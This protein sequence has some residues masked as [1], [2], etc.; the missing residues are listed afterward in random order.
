MAEI[1]FSPEEW[2]PIIAQTLA[3]PEP[4]ATDFA[5]RVSVPPSAEDAERDSRLM[6][7]ALRQ[8]AA[9][10][11]LDEVP[12]GCV[13]AHPTLGL[14]GHGHNRR[15]TTHDPTAHAE[16]I[17]IR[18]AAERIGTW[19]LDECELFVTLEP[20]PMC[21]GALV[22]ARIARV[23]FGCF[24]AKAG[25][26]GSVLRLHDHPV[27]NHRFPVASSVLRDACAEMLSEFFR[28]K[29]ALGKK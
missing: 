24:D 2:P 9:A 7:V 5:H 16:I 3:G 20:C 17:A 6:R 29:R 23:V 1:L 21:A 11:V 10:F 4:T 13:I 26:C 14:V 25:A 15:E 28:R 19:R 12:V 27:L 22:N 8:A 18:E